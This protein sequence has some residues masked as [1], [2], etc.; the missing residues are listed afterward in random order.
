MLSIQDILKL[1]EFA[2]AWVYWTVNREVMNDTMEHCNKNRKLFD[3]IDNTIMKSKIYYEND[4]LDIKPKSWKTEIIISNKRSFEAA[5]QYKGKKVAVLDFANSHSPWWAPFHS[6]AQEES[7]CRCSTLYP[8]L[9]T[10][11]N[12]EKYYG[13]HIMHYERGLSDIYWDDDIIYLPEIVVFKTDTSVPEVMHERDWFKVDVICAA[14]PELFKKLTYNKT[15]YEEIMRKRIKRILDLAYKE[16]VEVLV[17]WA[18]W[19]WAFRNPPEV[20]ARLFKEELA[21]YDFNTI[22]FPIYTNNFWPLNNYS[23]FREIFFWEKPQDMFNLE[24]FKEIQEKTHS[25]VYEE[26]SA[27]RKETHW[28]WYTFPQVEW[29]W[30]S[31]MSKKYAISWIEEAKEYLDDKA[32]RNNLKHLCG[33][34]LTHKDKNIEDIFWEIDTMKL[35]SSMTLFLQA[36]PDNKLFQEI[37]DEFYNWQL[38]HRTLKILWVRTNKSW[39]I[40]HTSFKDMLKE[41]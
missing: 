26:L 27:W 25:L 9:K 29:L 41:E 4:D 10:N 11:Y 31:T 18:F 39:K 17:L 21:N 36:E 19:C 1:K 38:D 16:W 8:C 5:S 40:K 7:L 30:Y 28:M 2:D 3:A 34:L 32:L 35:Q 13:I 20:V 6:W 15:R 24:R 22:E 12:L 14:A 33:A 23:I 37:I